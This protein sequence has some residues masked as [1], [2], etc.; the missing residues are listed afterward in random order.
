MERN[1]ILK[2]FINYFFWLRAFKNQM[3]LTVQDTCWARDHHAQ[4]TSKC[5]GYLQTNGGSKQFHCCKGSFQQEAD[6]ETSQADLIDHR[7]QWLNFHTRH[8]SRSSVTLY[9]I[10][11]VIEGP[12]WRSQRKTCISKKWVSQ[13]VKI[14]SVIHQRR[15]LL[16]SVRR[17]SWLT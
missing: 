14:I 2:S 7:S 10:E 17:N 15:K 6:Q 16:I 12:L 1:F 9:Y 3:G 8:Q 11:T 4:L 5:T 13:G